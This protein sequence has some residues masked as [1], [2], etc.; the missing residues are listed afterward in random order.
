MAESI[1][2]SPIAEGA[3]T[4]NQLVESALGVYKEREKTAP[5]TTPSSSKN[6]PTPFTITG[7]K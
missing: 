6:D 7:S 2:W 3:K 4:S 1:N 5:A